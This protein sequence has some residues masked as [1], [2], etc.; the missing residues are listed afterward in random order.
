MDKIDGIQRELLFLIQKNNKNPPSEPSNNS[1]SF[2][3]LT[4]GALAEKG[5]HFIIKELFPVD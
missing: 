2:A 3:L 1:K 5:E 4:S